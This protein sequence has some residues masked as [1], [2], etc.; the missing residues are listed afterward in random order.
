MLKDMF[1]NRMDNQY[2]KHISRYKLQ[3]TTMRLIH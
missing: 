2:K 1:I 3:M